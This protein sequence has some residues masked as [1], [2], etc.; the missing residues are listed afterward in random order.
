MLNRVI[1][2]F[3]DQNSNG[4]K[5]ANDP[6]AWDVDNDGD[7]IQ[8]SVWIDLGMPVQHAS[9]GRRYKPLFA[10]LIQDLDGRININ[11]AGNI[12]QLN[13]DPVTRLPITM[14]IWQ[15]AT[16]LYTSI[17]RQAFGPPMSPHRSP[18]A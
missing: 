4:I 6:S 16:H 14:S 9:D 10:F 15:P 1:Q 3:W 17:P 2:G 18:P 7:G 5:D 13:Y 8:D 11:A 12:A